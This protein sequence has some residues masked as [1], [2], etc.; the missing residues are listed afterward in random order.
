MMKSIG[1]AM[2][3]LLQIALLVMFCILIY[4]I[5]GLDFL[6]DSFH[7]TCFNNITGGYKQN[8]I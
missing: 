4:A 3:P 1:R 7:K 5:I 8:G 2:V 6:K